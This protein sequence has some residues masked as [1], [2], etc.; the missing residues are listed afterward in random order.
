[1]YTSVDRRITSSTGVDLSHD[2]ETRMKVGESTGRQRAAT[3][4]ELQKCF[5]LVAGHLHENVDEADEPR[6]KIK[7]EM[8]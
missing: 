6:A 2:G 3:S 4:R 1:M 8:R 7:F 5:S